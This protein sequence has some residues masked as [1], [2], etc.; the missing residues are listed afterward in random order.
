M[1]RNDKKNPPD[2]DVWHTD[3]TFKDN[4]PFA[5]ILYSKIIPNY[6]GDTLWCCLS[7]AYNALPNDIKK[8]SSK[9]NAIY[10]MGDFRNSFFKKK[11]KNSIKKFNNGYLKFGSAV[12][13]IIKK[14]PITG[15]KILYI[16]PGF[17][18]HILGLNASD[19][20][21]L[22]SYLFNFMNK[23]EFQIRFKWTS[24][25]IAMW[26]NRCTM[27]YALSDYLPNKRLMHRITINRDKNYK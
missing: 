6:G 25:T 10:D 19:S 7:T 17:T 12:H 8:Y 16:N 2:T 22:L 13:P 5:S 20:N 27:H 9:L 1:L 24:N 14:H 11:N 26:D 15:N 4:P 18:N 21:N 3:L 23:P